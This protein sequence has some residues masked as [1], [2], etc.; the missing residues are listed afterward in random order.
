MLKLVV[1]SLVSVAV[2]S[3]NKSLEV[4]GECQDEATQ[5]VPELD[6]NPRLTVRPLA[7]LNW[8]VGHGKVGL[9]DRSNLC[10]VLEYMREC[11]ILTREWLAVAT[12]QLASL[13]AR[14]AE[15]LYR[16]LSSHMN[17]DWN[18]LWLWVPRNQSLSSG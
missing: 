17:G 8:Q 9:R 10:R 15:A 16:N 3:V 12:G 5:V 4:G 18:E 11:T 13:S 2:H 7:G 14:C 6:T 1:E